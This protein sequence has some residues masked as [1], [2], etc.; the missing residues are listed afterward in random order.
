MACRYFL[1]KGFSCDSGESSKRKG[2]W[3]EGFLLR[4][5]INNHVLLLVRNV[6]GEGHSNEVRGRNEKHVIGNLR[7]SC[8]YYKVAKNLAESCSCSSVL[9]NGGHSRQL[10]HLLPGMEP[11]TV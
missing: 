7:K 3:R 2:S 11:A 8:L 1:V 6:A 10:S 4:E 5:H 9:W